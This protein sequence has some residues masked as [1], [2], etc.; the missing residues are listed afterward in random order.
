MTE[1]YSARVWAA[2]G[3]K[4]PG[5]ELGTVRLDRD[6]NTDDIAVETV[7]AQLTIAFERHIKVDPTKPIDHQVTT[8]EN[9]IQHSVY[10]EAWYEENQEPRIPYYVLS[11]PTNGRIELQ[12]GG[13]HYSKLVPIGD[14]IA[15]YYKVQMV[16]VT[17]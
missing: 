2:L 1:Y 15:R 8:F 11:K 12:P 5:F 17:L 7:R 16:E 3:S 6:P 14:F 4:K 10:A 13:S 9:K